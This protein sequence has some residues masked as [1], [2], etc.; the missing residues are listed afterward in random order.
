MY[1]F[2]LTCNS[3]FTHIYIYI[4][5]IYNMIYNI[6]NILYIMYIY[7]YMYIY[8]Y[9]NA[10]LNVQVPGFNPAQVGAM[11]I[12]LPGDPGGDFFLEGG[13]SSGDPTT[14]NFWVNCN[15]NM[16]GT[17]SILREYVNYPN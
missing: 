13:C 5:Y 12:C 16:F 3:L 2:D 8:I 14:K 7:K 1:M 10:Q 9:V 4:I 6:L 11:S 17:R 15:E